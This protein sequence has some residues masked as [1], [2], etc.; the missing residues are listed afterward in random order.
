[1]HDIGLQPRERAIL[2]GVLRKGANPETTAD[3]LSE[4]TLLLDTAGAD[5]ADVLTQERER[6]D[7]STAIGKGKVEELKA[8]I[9]EHQVQMVVFDD[10]LSPAQ[11]RNLEKA[12]EIKV[13]DRTGVILD[14]FAAHAHSAEARTQVELA[15]L[16]YLLPRLTRMWTHLSKQFGGVGTKGPGE[17][18]IETDRRM[19]RG[20]MQ[21]LQEKL[22]EIDIQRVVQ[23]KGREG[24]PRF[25][26][27]GYTNAGKSSM[28]RALTASDVFIEDRLFATLDTT[29]RAF[30]MPSGQKVL[31]SDTVGFIRKLPTQLVASFRTT[32]A[33]TMEADVLIHVVDITH[34]SLHDH[35]K[36]VNETIRSLD[37][38]DTPMILVFNKIDALQ[39]PHVMDDLAIEFPGCVFVSA[40]RSLNI[41]RLIQ[42][43]QD[44][45]EQISVA[46]HLRIPYDR[47]QD[48]SRVYESNE[49]VQRTDAEEN[50]LLVVKVPT[51]KLASF[52]TRYES[53]VDI[54]HS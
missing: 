25:A 43:M 5:V 23:R 13:L 54:E 15:Q 33:E 34:R 26:L 19:F 53:Y 9:E 51:D 39:E 37:A 50:V 14:I 20:R 22:K 49:V 16:N 36:V 46:V 32:L 3:H 30:E 40:E 11:V 18:Q 2:V 10:E 41:Q 47:M 52:R 24:L 7:L 12:L 42:Q 27:V 8:L 35:I 48:V 1:M 4:L 17:T 28:M 38:H 31:I 45:L 21:R 44:T 6:P 29:V